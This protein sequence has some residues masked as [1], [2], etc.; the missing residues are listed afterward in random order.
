MDSWESFAKN[1]NN[2]VIVQ[3]EVNAIKDYVN[4]ILDIMD[5]IVN[6]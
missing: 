5:N 2:V 1:F 3:T 6:S 4:V